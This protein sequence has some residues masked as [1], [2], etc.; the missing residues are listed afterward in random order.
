MKRK[1]LKSGYT[2]GA[3]AAAAARGAALMLRD[4]ETFEEVEITLP[5]GEKA[6]FRLRGQEISGDSASCFVIKDAGDDPDVT[7][8]AEIHATVSLNPLSPPFAKG[9][10]GGFAARNPPVSKPNTR[11]QMTF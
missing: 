2:T 7:H 10:M 11:R 8:G 1:R 4:R 6:C 5:G 3:C 9:G